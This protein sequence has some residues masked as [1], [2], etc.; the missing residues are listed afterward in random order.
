[1]KR[2]VVMGQAGSFGNAWCLHAAARLARRLGVPCV[3]ATDVSPATHGSSGWVATAAVGALAHPVMR[4]ADTAV[5][6]HFRPLTVGQAWVRGLG[7]AHAGTN[8]A[9]RLPGLADIRDSLMHMAWTPHLHRLLR[10]PALAHLQVFHLRSPA[11]TDFW[12]HA[13]E[14]RLQLCTPAAAQAA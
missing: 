14:H 12:L 3:P 1:M 11:E 10:L 7:A 6:L 4:S 2:V 9:D 5:W 8:A 13:Q